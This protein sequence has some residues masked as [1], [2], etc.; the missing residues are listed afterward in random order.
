M[1]RSLTYESTDFTGRVRD[2]GSFLNLQVKEL[3]G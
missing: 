3:I 1:Q 2:A